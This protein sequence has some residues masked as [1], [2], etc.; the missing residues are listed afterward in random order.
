MDRVKRSR[1]EGLLR[2][3]Q[4]LKSFRDR[5]VKF[6]I[7]GEYAQYPYLDSLG[8]LVKPSRMKEI[9]RVMQEKISDP[10]TDDT[11]V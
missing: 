3:G 4:P 6:D 5:S 8:G 1:E 7:Y 11:V 9:E 2:L 10:G